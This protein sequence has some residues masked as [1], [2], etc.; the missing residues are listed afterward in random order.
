[1]KKTI[2]ASIV[3]I[4][5][6]GFTAHADELK[7]QTEEDKL[8]YSL[9]MMIGER[10]IKSYQSLN[11]EALMAGIKTQHQGSKT[12]LT[13]EQAMQILSTFREKMTSKQSGPAKAMGEK[14][15]AKN[16]KRKEVKV[17]KSGLQYEVI[18]S[19]EGAKPK[20]TDTV[21]V[22]YQGTLINGTEFDSSYKRKQ[23]ASFPLNRVI[24]GWTEGLQLMSVG[25]KYRFVIP[26]DL[27]YGDRGAGQKIGPGA[28]LIFEVEL[29]KIK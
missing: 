13:M 9:G 23:P 10:V 29:L 4:A 28:T 7:L 25:S 14:Y 17:T 11:Y 24:R 2:A 15:R 22:H 27:A 26:S 16:A 5:W 20:A 19:A 8:S 1:M 21:T 3:A 12:S 6:I 18:T